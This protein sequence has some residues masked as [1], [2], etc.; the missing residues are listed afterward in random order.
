MR[1]F[2]TTILLLAGL[3]TVCLAGPIPK[4]DEIYRKWNQ[5]ESEVC[6][7]NQPGCYIE[8]FFR[9]LGIATSVRRSVRRIRFLQNYP[10]P[11]LLRIEFT[12]NVSQSSIHAQQS[13][14]DATPAWRVVRDPLD[15]LSWDAKSTA[16]R[17][18][19]KRST[20]EISKMQAFVERFYR[21]NGMPKK[22]AAVEDI[23]VEKPKRR[24]KYSFAA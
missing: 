23:Q 4:L 2:A 17:D 22:A 19:H 12:T 3:L 11:I 16:A 18:H 9:S 15:A 14:R 20:G 7:A 24:I 1:F 13:H 6:L 21:K 8:A 5:G 10:S